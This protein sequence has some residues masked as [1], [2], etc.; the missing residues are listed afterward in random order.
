VGSLAAVP[1]A[2]QKGEYAECGHEQD[3][4]AFLH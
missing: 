3:N 1:A 2:A 4:R